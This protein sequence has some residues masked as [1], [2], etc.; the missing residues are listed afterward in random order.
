MMPRASNDGPDDRALLE[1]FRRG[2]RPALGALVE[3]HKQALYGVIVAMAGPGHDADE[4]F[5]ETWFRALKHIATYR[6]A[7]FRAWLLCIA[8]NIVIDRNRARRDTVSLDG[9]LGTDDEAGGQ[10]L[11][12]LLPARGNGPDR[13][14]VA[15]EVRARIEAEVARLPPDQRAVFML[16]MTEDMPF[17]EIAKIQGVSINTVLGRMKYAVDKL[18]RALRDETGR[19]SKT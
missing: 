14:M 7:N 9:A 10:S 1:R 19:G 13:M 5:Q 15:A 11:L 3:R 8:R 16:R 12:D 2:D 17:K 4:V 6:H 18:R